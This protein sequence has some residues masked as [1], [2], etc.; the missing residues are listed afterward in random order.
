M[1]FEI[2]S[3]L[4]GSVLFEADCTSLF[5]CLKLALKA[6]ANLHRA[7]LHGADLRGAN[8]RG[9]DLREAN[10]RGANLIRSDLREA[11]LIEANLRGANLRG[12]DLRGANLIRSNLR[13][14]NL[15]RSD[16]READLIGANL[17]RAKGVNSFR[18]TPLKILLDQPGKIRAYKLVKENLEGPYNGGI[19]YHKGKK[20]EVK[21]A[22]TDESEH[23]GAGINLATLDWVM[24]EWKEGF[25][26]LVAEFTAK[27]IA[28]IP[29][30]TDGKFRVFRCKIVGEK[31][32]KEIG[33]I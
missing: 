13:G 17:I 31:D 27:D 25:K 8:L 18:C 22:N 21:D 4:N 9:A 10:L 6:K 20:V 14:A 15:I 7:N 1:K 2:K 5:E 11:D 3:W 29:T 32:L 24:R 30:A 23:C 19:K 28:A 26:I 16:L 33:L 12:A